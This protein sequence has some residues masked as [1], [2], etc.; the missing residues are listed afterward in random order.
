M[1]GGSWKRIRESVAHFLVG[2]SAKRVG[3]RR[4]HHSVI[5]GAEWLEARELLAV[6]QITFDAAS[7]TVLIEGTSGADLAE[8]TQDT[9]A[10]LV[11]VSLTN[12]TGVKRATFARSAISQVQFIGGEGDD[13]L[14]HWTDIN[15]FANGGG[16]NDKLHGGGG[17]NVIYG[18]SGD[19]QIFGNAFVDYLYG[20][21]GNDVIRAGT[22]NDIVRGGAGNDGLHGEGGSD[23]LYG[24]A[25]NDYLD[26]GLDSDLLYGGAGD[27]QLLGGA[28]G[29]DA[30]YGEAGND[31]LY[32]HGGDDFL[33]GGAGNDV[34]VGD[35][36]NDVLL[37]GPGDDNLR[38]GVG[39]DHLYGQNGYDYLE[40]N[41]GN[42][43]LWGGSDDDYMLGGPGNNALF[44]DDGDDQL[45]GGDE[46]DYIDA[47]AGDDRM[48][49]AG[50]AD[51]VRGGAGNDYLYGD[52]GNDQLDGQEGNDYLQGAAG[53][54]QLV[55]GEGDDYMLGGA[56]D[57]YLAGG[58]GR[59]ALFGEDGADLLFGQGDSDTI[60]GGEGNDLL[61]GGLG[62][63]SMVGGGGDDGL[64]GGVGIDY[65]SGNS[66]NDFLVG[67]AGDDVLAGGNG[68]DVVIGGL[69]K[70]NLKGENDDDILIGGAT[71]YDA[72][73][74]KL[75]ALT[76]A[77]AAAVPYATRTA[78]IADELFSAHLESQETVFDDLVSDSVL[79]GWGQDW[80]FL[81]G[82]LGS[83]RPA[84]VIVDHTQGTHGHAPIIINELPALEGFEFIDAL[85]QLSDRLSTEAVHTLIPHADN[86]TLQREHLTLYELIR[87]DE[88]TNIA[89]R[90]GLWS[91]PATWRNG[92]VPTN[93]ARVLVPVGVN[94][95]V[96]GIIAA[97]IATVRVDGKLSFSTNRNTQLKVDTV[98]VTGSG[99]FEM[100]TS[101]Q[102]IASNVTA[103]LLITDNGAIDR[104][105]DPFGISRGLI[106]HGSVSI[107]GAAVTPY[108]GLSYSVAAGTRVLT[109]PSVPVNWKSGD[110]VVIASTVENAANQNEV[111]QIQSISGTVVTLSSP[112]SYNH[113]PVP[114]MQVHVTNTS[115]NASIESEAFAFDRRG[116]VMFMH[117]RDVH[118]E[119]GGFYYLGR[120]DKSIPINDSVVGAD[121]VLKAG[122]GTNQ[123]ARYAVHFHRN[124][125]TN[126]GNPSTIVGSVVVDSPG[127]GFV[128]H[129]SYVD[130]TANVAWAV[131]GASFATEV[132]DEIGSFANNLAVGTTGS[133]V[134]DVDARVGVQD[135]GFQGDGFWFQGGGVSV[136]GNISAGNQGHA[137]AFYTRGLFE[138]GVQKH[139]LAANL[140]DPS[141][142]Q[143]AEYISVGLVPIRQFSSNVGYSSGEGLFIRFHMQGVTHGGRTLIADSKFWNNAI[144]I[145]LHYAEGVTLRGL[146][147]T[148]DSSS[149]PLFGVIAN[150]QEGFIRYEN[151]N[152]SG[153]T[154]GI[155]MPVWGDNVVEG[156]TFSNNFVDVLIPTAAGKPRKINL[157]NLPLTS[158]VAAWTNMPSFYTSNVANHFV[159]DEVWLNYGP[160]VNRRLYALVQKA[161][162]VPFPAARPDA[163]SQYIGLTT[164]QLWNKFGVAIGG[165]VA[166]S[167]AISLPN[168]TGLVSLT[169]ET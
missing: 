94:V 100:G 42:D 44:G 88:L 125:L 114:G 45:F 21:D 90:S 23:T 80:F 156:G 54:D 105:K 166:P 3:R 2:Q 167:N 20:D 158:K 4:Q 153:F 78:T 168:I 136:T 67:G 30:L 140:S 25:G 77:W 74:A 82:F 41:A 71:V 18:G 104:A 1:P 58:N 129:S 34:L 56:G 36:G 139:F 147:V 57:D 16:G 155:M 111:R 91:D 38:G 115:R 92:Q 69:G 93:G 124:G 169:S 151:M 121:W 81:T 5:L 99:E 50:G 128:N 63:D 152:V 35:S 72:D 14:T 148:H 162:A 102:P 103:W 15:L 146:T 107:H 118:I 8:L 108:V 37:G 95:R 66:G 22:G 123:R 39:N 145:E 86:A 159:Y 130:M 89:V 164:Q 48:W 76:A 65:L 61:D 87:Y 47:G 53:N 143:G 13:E 122:T 141:I 83:Y 112:L 31:S 113:T 9:N 24:D 126:D 64:L 161:D 154:N 11:Y 40:G 12:S 84:D 19:D 109:L 62:D 135:F 28:S 96:D 51:I 144:G 17:T 138:G 157:I 79:G 70:D 46:F 165:K 116:H 137:F 43:G 10:G 6:N 98:V 75:W 32:G 55:G 52:D 27:D 132:G 26:G 49:G 29:D 68:N 120:T 85:D 101:A 134:G 149:R 163:P 160:Y 106:S 142:A 97:R 33:D 7:R 73:P 119:Y 59:D 110:Y 60:E 117:D 133:W 131:R 127:W 150:A